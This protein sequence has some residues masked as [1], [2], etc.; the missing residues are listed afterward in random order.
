MLQKFRLPF[1]A[2]YSIVL[3]LA[4]FLSARILF[5]VID[6]PG[7]GF[8]EIFPSFY[9]GL[10]LDVSAACYLSLIPVFLFIG[11]AFSTSSLAEK[12]LHFYMAFAISIIAVIEITS[13]FLYREWGNTINYRA[14]RYLL[15]PT[16]A[17]SSVDLKTIISGLSLT[18]LF[19]LAWIF[20]FR[21]L[22]FPFSNP[23]E[24]KWTAGFALVLFP[25]LFI[26]IRGSVGKISISESHAYFSQN[27]FL[28]QA[29]LNKAW[30]F[31]RNVLNNVSREKP[32]YYFPEFEQQ[33]FLEKLY[34]EGKTVQWLNHKQPNIVLIIL[35]SWNTDVIG[36]L[37]GIKKLSPGFDSLAGNGIL[38]TN[39]YGSGTRTDQGYI[40]LLSGFPALPDLSIVQE[41]EK[42][43]KL[44]SLIHDF[45]N[46]GY[47]TSLIYG[48]D[49]EFCNFKTYFVSQGTE[50]LISENDFS[51]SEKS[52]AWGIP[53]HILF[54]RANTELHQNKEPFF[55]IIPTQS[56][57]QPFDSPVETLPENAGQPE[58]YNA[59][60]RYMDKAISKFMAECRNEKWYANT[61][62]ILVADHGNPLPLNRDYNDHERFHIPMLFFGEVI[63]STFRG[64]KISTVANHH[65][66]PATLLAQLGMSYESYPFSKNIFSDSVVPFAYWST[67]N[68]MGW[69]T[70][71]QKIGINL[72]NAEVF[73]HSKELVEEER[74]NGVGYVQEILKEY[75]K[76]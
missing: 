59:C 41:I 16:D 18:I 38:F 35:E 23:S 17:A 34:P 64:T 60:V 51:K 29:A 12:L 7:F 3:W 8:A 31:S 62:F 39:M 4:V 58:K 74:K 36:S 30:Y 76:Y 75:E 61:L 20:V 43:V 46:S 72:H 9:K 5:V 44:P 14:V 66:L 1:F 69:I 50:K 33:Q 27:N 37:N 40:S 24:K 73:T 11:N 71:K 53:D 47:H 55:S 56:S 67:D 28:N 25:L 6:N 63:D 49:L 42:S 68:T 32:F 15:Y 52:I 13:V 26:G 57:H 22:F 10:L 19:S 21:K 48:F 70:E 45:K 54:P 2:F 65:D